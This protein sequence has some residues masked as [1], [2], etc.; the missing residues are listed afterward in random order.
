MFGVTDNLR[1]V[2]LLSTILASAMWASQATAQFYKCVDTSG[3]VTFSDQGCGADEDAAAVRVAPANTLD[4][5]PYRQQQPGYTQPYA[6]PEPPG[7]QTRVT[8]VRGTNDA[9][10]QRQKLCKE[11]STPLR[12]AHG[13][14]ASQRATAARVCSQQQP[15]SAQPYAAPEPPITQTRV[16]VVGGTN[17]AERQ[18]QKLCKEAS[19]PLRGAHGLTASQRATA[20]QVCA[21]VS[22]PVPDYG[23]G[24]HSMPAQTPSPATITSCDSGGCWDTN[25]VRYNRGAG[26][27]HFPS[28]G[29]PACQLIGGQMNCP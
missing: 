28:H 5:S 1:A 2:M 23:A 15:A 21:G 11:A 27:T 6:A 12:G 17:D 29:G 8:V 4:S 18:R 3:K 14:T 24:S 20:A 26:A 19:T 13:L 25:G 9:E 7:T 22:V 10:R 16:T